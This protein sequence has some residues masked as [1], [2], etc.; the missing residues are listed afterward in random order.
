MIDEAGHILFHTGHV[1]HDMNDDTAQ[2]TKTMHN[3]TNANGE[4][5]DIVIENEKTEAEAEG[6]EGTS[7]QTTLNVAV[8][9]AEGTGEEHSE[10]STVNE[11]SG[12]IVGEERHTR[13]AHSQRHERGKKTVKKQVRQQQQKR[14]RRFPRKTL[15]SN[16]KIKNEKGETITSREG[17]AN[18]FW[19]KCCDA[20]QNS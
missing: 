17:I 11:E 2:R 15:K 16:T 5:T 10:L 4:Q 1:E 12:H 20:T 18:I 19:T 9:A 7:T 6:I 3:I 13:S 14:L 8:E